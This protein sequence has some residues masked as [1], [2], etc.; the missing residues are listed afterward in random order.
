LLDTEDAPN[1]ISRPL[2]ILFMEQF[3]PIEKN[4]IL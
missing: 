2:L 1:K 3:S 4:N